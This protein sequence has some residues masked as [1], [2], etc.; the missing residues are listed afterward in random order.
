MKKILL[1]LTII[2]T[3]SLAQQP[4]IQH[5]KSS[6]QYYYGTGIAVNEPEA[7][8]AAL[9]E[10]TK[11]IAVRVTSE[12]KR[13]VVETSK[14]FSET[15]N[16]ILS[17]Y[18]LATITN[19]EK[20]VTQVDGKIEV[21]VYL[22][23]SEVVKLFESR[24]KLVYDIYQKAIQYEAGLNIGYALKSYYFAVV[25]MNSIPSNEIMLEGKN[26]VTE[27]PFRINEILSKTKFILKSDRK[28]AE[29]ERELIFNVSCL[30]KPVQLI[31][32]TFW[33][34]TNQVQV[35]GIDGECVLRL[36]GSSV[37]FDKINIDIK[38][39]YYESR[40]EIKEVGDLWN[41]VVKPAFN[42]TKQINLVNT[43]VVKEEKKEAKEKS[44]EIDEP[45]R[46]NDFY[47]DKGSYKLNLVCNDS[48]K[49]V[50]RIG[51]ETLRFL[52]TLKGNSK[53]GIG[54]SYSYDP[55]LKEK[56][57]RLIKYNH[58][59]IVGESI[60]AGIN[61]TMTG[62]EM[63][64]IRVLNRYKS[65]NKQSSEYIVLDFDKEGSLYDVTFGVLENV[66][67][68]IEDQAKYGGDWINRQ[69]IMKFVEKYRTS[70]LCRDLNMIDSLF[71]D[72]AVIIV[73]RIMKKTSIKDGYKYMKI[74]DEQP[75]ASY[76]KLTKEQ[77]L[78]NLESLFK[79]ADDIFIGYSSMEIIRKNAEKVYGI[80]M[81]Q[82]YNTSSY[83]DEGYLFLLVD[84][85][86]RQPQIYVRSWQPKEWDEGSLIRLSN[87][88]INR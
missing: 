63:R 65:I 22:D 60:D 10:L 6:G 54:K 79:R 59:V 70:F 34:G 51:K 25:L 52:E 32:F 21:F 23:K 62:W 4:S 43:P 33:D 69:T 67:N 55:F 26:L 83:S 24:K 42:F 58:P 12:F 81:R 8:D 16:N 68:K 28:T 36:L 14:D 13:D 39:N 49:V 2:A 37:N 5:I 86:G 85:E 57:E 40:D 20:I 35:R 77:Y 78:K 61:K 17:T 44:I 73:G 88:N 72:G 30:D 82:N 48:C 9:S 75:E 64:K 53:S 87:F 80:S 3:V 27:I 38:Y 19:H 71:A 31:E 46:K 66:Y 7:N 45:V 50:N 56:I 76:I 29:N 47:S 15:V 41:L 84:F 1:G 11:S 74:S 18:S